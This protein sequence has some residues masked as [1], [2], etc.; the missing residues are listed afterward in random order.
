M[1]LKHSLRV[2]LL[3]LAALLSACSGGG[4]SDDGQCTID[5]PIPG[6]PC[7][8]GGGSS[9]GGTTGGA[10]KLTLTCPTSIAAG[11]VAQGFTATLTNNGSAA[12][13]DT[14][15]S[16]LPVQTD[17]TPFG[18]I[19][20][21]NADGTTNP[22]GATTNTLGKVP[23]TV[24]VPATST[25]ATKVTIRGANAPDSKTIFSATCVVNVTPNPIRL[26][27][28]G[29]ANEPSGAIELEAG[30]AKSG[31][32]A[33]LT[34]S[35]GAAIPE[36]DLTLVPVVEGS[37]RPGTITTPGTGVVTDTNGRVFFRYQAPA[38]VTDITD[39][40]LTVTARANGFTANRSY[41]VRVYPEA[42]EPPEP[43]PTLNITAPSG[44]ASG[45]VQIVSGSTN[46]G[47]FLQL[48]RG[49]GTAIV[50]Q[51]VTLSLSAGG[52]SAKAVT[53]GAIRVVPAR[54]PANVGITDSTGKVF[55]T[56]DAPTT[57][58]QSP[59]LYTVTASTSVNNTSLTGEFTVRVM[60]KGTPVLT[61]RA[62]GSQPSGSVTLAAGE[63][64]DGFI[65][66]LVDGQGKPLSGVTLTPS[67]TAGKVTSSTGQTSGT[68]DIDGD[69]RFDY[70]A[71]SGIIDPTQ[72]L[73][74]IAGTA[75]GYQIPAVE[76]VVNLG[77]TTIEITG[78]AG[79]TSGDGVE[80]VRGKSL[81]GFRMR[82]TDGVGRPL[83]GVRMTA[84]PHQIASTAAFGTVTAVGGRTTTDSDGAISFTYNAPSPTNNTQAII[85][86]SAT[87]AGQA[88]SS[89]FPVLVTIPGIPKLT[90]RGPADEPS[91]R[92]EVLPD[93]IVSGLSAT[94]VDGAGEPLVNKDIVL[95]ASPGTVVIADD[96][97]SQTDSTGRI[98][99][100]YT[101]PSAIAARSRAT[102][103]ARASAD[104][105]SLTTTYQLTLVPTPPQAVPQ[106]TLSGPSEAS[107]AQ[108][109]TGYTATFVRADGQS[110][111]GAP[112]R[113]TV[114][115]GTLAIVENGVERPGQTTGRT[116]AF[117]RLSFVITPNSG[118]ADSTSQITATYDSSGTGAS[119][120]LTNQCQTVSTCTTVLNVTVRADTFRFIAPVFGA[121]VPVG[122]T[123]AAA[124][125]FNWLSATGAG[126]PSCIDLDA[127]FQG[128]SNAPY[129]LVVGSDPTP[130]TQ[131]RRVQ[132]NSSGQIQ[133]RVA[134]YSDRSG[135]VTI[136]AREN[137]QCLESGGG[138]SG[139]SA[140]TAVQFVDEPGE[141]NNHVDLDVQ[142][143]VQESSDTGDQRRLPVTLDVRNNAYGVLDGEQVLFCIAAG[144]TT[145]RTTTGVA[146]NQTTTTTTTGRSLDI[147]E[148]VFPGGG[149]T[150]SEGKAT[151]Q[152]FVP[153][154]NLT[155][156]TDATGNGTVATASVDI[157]G[158]VRRNSC[159]ASN[160]GQVCSTRR[161]Q[162][163]P[164]SQ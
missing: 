111:E 100:D 124:L 149:T 18:E 143:R 98:R 44:Q 54:T 139:L 79:A 38:T 117:G 94:F 151:T 106:L 109:R 69:L 78:P 87:V 2:S 164:A 147:N 112:I 150:S 140:S 82:L 37:S 12:I 142:L 130:R 21:T 33:R 40:N 28:L 99:F 77:P 81:A 125:S 27:I 52:S 120:E 53:P 39:V 141:A 158:C 7:A 46:T 43:L 154:L 56:I 17:G 89:D 49:D 55:F 48:L 159:S 10:R 103:T 85:T 128:S 135:F 97:S 19:I 127:S 58:S 60:P 129:G 148:R 47:Y 74:R 122:V 95:T 116:D 123:N 93:G 63:R 5:P 31:F 161:V 104:G 61:L 118:S 121:E 30:T 73:I 152:Y 68:T 71:P 160:D 41:L 155:N 96:S 119:T 163:V 62:A 6:T 90:L 110:V 3:A 25:T 102:I 24:K 76:Y 13:K 11:T 157:S 108:K 29:P 88:I 84:R 138:S 132:L 136:T 32:V 153:A 114:S 115:G 42:V 22:G 107:P 156:T 162:I 4:S 131:V 35:T 51:S 72:A 36:I 9:S 26:T 86:A 64:L 65:A 113:L 105:S 16:L 126:V 83:V 146:P 8:D 34:D 137:R 70:T 50:G 20:A 91:A 59:Q 145:V 133:T 57:E 45:S 134:I 14:F 15:V 92:I 67:T 101:A 75:D 66:H 1:N 144:P 80:V 23:F